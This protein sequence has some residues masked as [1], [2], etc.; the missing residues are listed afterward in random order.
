M[1]FRPTKL[2]IKI[3]KYLM[4]NPSSREILSTLHLRKKR[5]NKLEGKIE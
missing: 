3:A 5:L 4:R 1:I 2:Q